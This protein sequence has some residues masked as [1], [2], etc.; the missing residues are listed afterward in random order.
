MRYLFVAIVIMGFLTG[1]NNNSDNT[2]TDDSISTSG[3]TV[4][5]TA[6]G[7]DSVGTKMTIT[8]NSDTNTKMEQQ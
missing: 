6:P 7:S 3:V 4:D 2:K 8:T 5:T 1:C